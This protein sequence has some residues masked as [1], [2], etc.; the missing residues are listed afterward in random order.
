MISGYL[1]VYLLLKLKLL[2]KGKHFWLRSIFAS[3]IGEAIFTIIAVTMIEFNKAPPEII[4]KIILTSY[5]IKIICS[6]LSSFPAN[7]FVQLIKK[8]NSVVA[9]EKKIIKD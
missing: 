7:L 9:Y 5:S 6:I 3:L 2:T 1:N 4:V 8:Y